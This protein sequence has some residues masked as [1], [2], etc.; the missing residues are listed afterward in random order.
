MASLSTIKTNWGLPLV[1]LALSAFPFAAGVMRLAEVAQGQLTPE[2]ARLLAAP[3]PLIVHIVTS[4][5][6]SVVG[7]FQF[8]PRFR[9]QVPTWHRR[10]GWLLSLC[11][12]LSGMSGLWMNQFYLPAAQDGAL[13]YL[14]RLFFGGAMVASVLIGFAAIRK[15]DVM[16]HRL[17]M[18]R[19]YAIGLGAGTQALDHLIWL[20]FMPAPGETGRAMLM[21]AGWIINL[22]VVEWAMRKSQRRLPRTAVRA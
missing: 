18:A 12:L 3:L 11:A 17:W 14:F 6:F 1:L 9:R 19:A 7:A 16:R 15:K 8:A 20:S 5:L 2:N 22:A 21:G 10:A 13:L 4:G